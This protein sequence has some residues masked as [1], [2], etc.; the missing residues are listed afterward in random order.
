MEWFAL[1]GFFILMV[2]GVYT[3]VVRNG[4]HQNYPLWQFSLLILATM[5]GMYGFLTSLLFII[6]GN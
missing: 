3:F 4:K 6:L 5:V 1:V 2:F